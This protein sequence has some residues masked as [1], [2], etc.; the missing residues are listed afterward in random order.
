MKS[1]IPKPPK[2]YRMLRDGERKPSGYQYYKFNM[3]W[4][5]GDEP[6]KIY[7][8]LHMFPMCAPMKRAKAKRKKADPKSR[9]RK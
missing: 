3:W 7:K 5:P 2:G 1:E 6:G 4:V 8:T 9:R